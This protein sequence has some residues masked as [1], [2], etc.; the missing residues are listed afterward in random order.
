MT[1]IHPKV[2]GA[3]IGSLIAALTVAIVTACGVHVP[4]EVATPFAG[5]LAALGGWISP[6]P[7]A[8]TPPNVSPPAPSTPAQP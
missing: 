8:E 6:A 4:A 2:A 1:T 3:T 5:L 7:A